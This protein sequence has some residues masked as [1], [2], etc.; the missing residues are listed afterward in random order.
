M[1]WIAM[2]TMLID[3]IGAIFFPTELIWRMI[4]RLSFPIYLYLLVSG[5]HRTR[6]YPKYA[7]RL[8]LLA[9]V[10]QLP[11]QYAFDTTRFNVIASLLVCLLVL[12]LLDSPKVFLFLKYAGVIAAIFLMEWLPFD[13][14]AY[15]LILCLIY[16]Y[17]TGEQ[18]MIAHF[19]TEIAAMIRYKWSIQF[20]SIMVS[21]VINVHPNLIQSLTKFRAPSI[22]WRSFYPLHLIILVLISNYINLLGNY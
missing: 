19:I 14:G 8:T 16:R 17:L 5:Y 7:L 4:G 11:Y 18:L 20:I 9:I 2:I 6:S 12:K 13:Y 10:S 15:G 1:Q 22:I 3:H 21:Y